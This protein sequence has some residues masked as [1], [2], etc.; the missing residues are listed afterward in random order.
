MRKMHFDQIAP[1]TEQENREA[2]E[3]G[4]KE[5]ENFA[6]RKTGYFHVAKFSWFC[7]KN[8]IIFRGF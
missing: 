3:E 8:M 2:E 7:L 1:N 4:V 6:Y 5:A